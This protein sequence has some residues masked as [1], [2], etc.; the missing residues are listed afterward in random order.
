LHDALLAESVKVTAFIDIDPKKIGGTKRGKPVFAPE[1]LKGPGP[2][3]IV[4]AVGK[5]GGRAHIRSALTAMGF[6]EGPDFLL[7]A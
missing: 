4:G 1:K 5:R 6:R 7:A 2:E 3:L